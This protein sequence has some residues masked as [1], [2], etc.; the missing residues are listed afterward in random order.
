MSGMEVLSK[1]LSKDKLERAEKALLELPQVECGVVHSF[2]PGVYIRQVKIP[3]DTFAIGHHQNFEH[4]NVLVKGRVTMLM[5]D[6]TTKE[7]RAPMVFTAKPGR[8]ISYV[9]EEIIWMNIYATDEQ[10][11]EKLEA[12]ILT[13]SDSWLETVEAKTKMCLLKSKV[14]VDDFHKAIAEMGTPAET[15]RAISENEDDMTPLPFGSFKIKVA[16]SKIEGKGLFATAAIEPGELIAPAR[17]S[18]RRTIAGRFTNHS[19]DPNAVMVRAGSDIGLVAKRLI[20]G[21]HGGLDGEE[22]TIDYRQAVKLNLEIGGQTC[23][24]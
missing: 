9:H 17:I 24:A 6:G 23:P 20:H 2:G 16:D 11:I 13:K 10:D 15:V 5:D 1:F 12:R 19:I 7:F 3:S 22:I 14:D 8:K 4:S 21:C 18:G